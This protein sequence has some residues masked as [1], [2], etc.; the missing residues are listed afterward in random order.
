MINFIIDNWAEIFLT[1]QTVIRITP[2]KKDDQIESKW[3]KILNTLVLG[4]KTK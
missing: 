2:T 1:V 3:G 4:S